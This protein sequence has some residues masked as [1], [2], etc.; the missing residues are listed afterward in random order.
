MTPALRGSI[1]II[2]AD[3]LLP[4]D[5]LATSSGALASNCGVD[6]GHVGSDPSHVG[7]EVRF[8]STTRQPP[9]API[10]IYAEVSC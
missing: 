10:G 7:L 9:A 6:T 4:D 5:R 1:L 8:V 2:R 3:E